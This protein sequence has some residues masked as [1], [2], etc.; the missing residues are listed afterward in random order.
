M[1]YFMKKLVVVGM[2]SA[3]LVA[4]GGGGGGGS[5]SSGSDP[6]KL[7]TP[8]SNVLTIKGS[9]VNKQEAITVDKKDIFITAK[10]NQP[11][12]GVLFHPKGS[13]AEGLA[14]GWFGHIDFSYN[15]KAQIGY[16]DFGDKTKAY[17]SCA[18][19]AC[20]QNSFY[21]FQIGTQQ[22]ILT[23]N[24]D[25]SPNTYNYKVNGKDRTTPV[26]VSGNLQFTFPSN[27]PILQSQ[28]F[29]K[30]VPQGEFYWGAYPYDV[31]A[32]P[33]S[34]K[35]ATTNQWTHTLMVEQDDSDLFT[36]KVTELSATT[37][38]VSMS[39]GF[40]TYSAEV[41]ATKSPWQE[42][43]K[44]VNLTIGEPQPQGYI[45]PLEL[46]N[47]D[48]SSS[49]NLKAR[50]VIPK[51]VLDLTI[52]GK[53]PDK[54]QLEGGYAE[55]ESKYYQLRLEQREDGATTYSIL[56]I[57]QAPDGHLWLNYFGNR[58]SLRCGDPDKACAG[59]SVDADQHTYRFNNVKAG[60]FIIH[61]TAY[62]PGVLK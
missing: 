58:K 59:L 54:I 4:C 22:T 42:N 46:W 12:E 19:D 60:E 35:N 23:F 21:D 26:K 40:E 51:P 31:F 34:E 6:N 14:P 11:V 13:S 47:E 30:A 45:L 53:S 9:G 28:R 56:N 62:I 37:F 43:D 61:G 25:Q 36:L 24:F 29:P 50:L 18:M 48:G 16:L 55:N 2:M 7:A 10:G 15:Y 17:L 38:K 44:V 32:F 1:V 8:A 5:S 52:D 39:D 49:Q 27:W 3:G 33:V 41:V 57:N 20:V